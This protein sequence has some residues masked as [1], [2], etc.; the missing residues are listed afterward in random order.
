MMIAVGH[1]G[2]AG[3]EPENTLR[4]FRRAIALGVDY[5]E[6]DV[7]LTRDGELAV[8]HDETVDRTTSGHGRVGDFTMEEL[9]QLDAGQ[10]ERIPTLEEVLATTR[11]HVKVLVELKGAGVEEKTV[12]TVRAA[13][14]TGDVI[15]TSFHLERIERVRQ[16]DP[17]LTTGAI[18][19]QPPPDFCER[20]RAAGATTLGV[21]HK[22]L[23]A[24]RVREAQSQGFVLRAWNPDTEPEME[25]MVDL[26]V[27]GIGSNRPDLL[28]EVL[29]RRSLR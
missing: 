13:G 28:L 18:F 19:S 25:A 8:I 6:C 29:K 17:S 21:H 11:G 10:G 14:M 23:T 22:S 3:I 4:G 7:H 1:R 26:G 2:A 24:E 15:F 12:E 27:D 20:A 9:W 16:I 5:V